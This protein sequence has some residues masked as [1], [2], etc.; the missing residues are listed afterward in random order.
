MVAANNH[1][2]FGEAG[3]DRLAEALALIIRKVAAA[4]ISLGNLSFMDALGSPDLGL[5]SEAAA[6]LHQMCDGLREVILEDNRFG[7]EVRLVRGDNG[8]SGFYPLTVADALARKALDCDDPVLA[9]AWLQKVLSTSHADGVSVGALWGVPV[10]QRIELTSEV[11][12]V[13]M[14][15]VP[16]CSQK[17]WMENRLFNAMGSTPHS[18]LNVYPSSSALI[19]KRR[20]EPYIVLPDEDPGIAKL[21][22]DQFLATH[23]LFRDITLVLTVVGPRASLPMGQWFTFEDSDLQ[24]AGFSAG[25]RTSSFIEILP[26][27]VPNSYPPLD[28]IE[29][30]QIVQAFIALV[31]RVKDRIRVSI[32]RINQA[33]RRRNVGDQAVELCTALETLVGDDGTAEMT[34]KVKV[35]ATRLVGGSQSIRFRNSKL[36]NEAYAIRSKLVHTGKVD[37][38]KKTL[39]GERHLSRAEIVKEAVGIAVDLIKVLIRRGSIPEWSEFDVIEQPVA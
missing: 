39:I 9:I 3:A 1:E 18:A 36:L 25:T 27:W 26:F 2:S 28:P 11:S 22:A 14:T 16:D 7:A 12:I 24:R 30:P 19:R 5:H 20:I 8:A 4:P 23:D 10:E 31:P 29:G 21:A 15:E 33:L 13:P 38:S 32:E 37:E 34:H 17:Q 35:R 6:R